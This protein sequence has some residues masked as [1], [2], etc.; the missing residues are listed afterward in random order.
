MSC[1]LFTK[2]KIYGIQKELGGILEGYSSKQGEQNAL[3]RKVFSEMLETCYTHISDQEGQKV[4]L[5][6]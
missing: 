6:F 2:H 4:F 3:Y 5:F 1:I